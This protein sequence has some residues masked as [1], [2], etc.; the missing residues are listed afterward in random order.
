[1][2]NLTKLKSMNKIH[3][4]IFI[5]LSNH[6]SSTWKGKQLLEATKNN[7]KLIDIKFP[8]IDPEA[9]TTVIDILVNKYINEILSYINNDTRLED[10]I[11][12]IMGEMTFTYRMVEK[13]QNYYGIKCVAST[14]KRIV[15][16]NEENDKKTSRFEFIQFRNY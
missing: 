6:P 13:L 8:N 10:V 1:M 4:N 15:E 11:V 14:T 7:A 9:S 12:H 2:S 5:N 16:E 3:N